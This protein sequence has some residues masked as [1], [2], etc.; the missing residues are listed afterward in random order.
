MKLETNINIEEGIITASVRCTEISDETKEALHDY[1]KVLRYG[2]ID[3]SAKIK[4]NDSKPEIVSDDDPD[5][6]TVKIALIDKSFPVDENLNL[7]LI[8]DSA[9]MSDKELTTS[10]SDIEIL[11][12]AKAVIWVEKVTAAVKEIVAAARKQ[13]KADI[14]YTSEEII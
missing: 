10:V 12:K 9:K 5:G 7:E 3:F 8:L 2:S 1:P 13:N 6:E 14:E 11:S 4:V